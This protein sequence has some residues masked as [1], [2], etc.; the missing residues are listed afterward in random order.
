MIKK[1]LHKLTNYF[2]YNIRKYPSYNYDK[3][4]VFDLVINNYISKNKDQL[5]YFIQVGAHNGLKNDPINKYIKQNGWNGILIEP[6][7]NIF[8]ELKENYK[9]FS[10]NLIFENIAISS[11]ENEIELFS[12]K[13]GNKSTAA[14]VRKDVAK[15][16]LKKGDKLLQSIKVKSM[17]LKDLINKHSVKKIDLLQIDTEGYDFEVIKTLDL[18][19]FKP[20][21]IQF[22]F[23]HL[24]PKECNDVVKYLSLNNYMIHWGGREG[25]AIAIL[26]YVK[27]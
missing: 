21:I 14:S 8:N 26:K 4:N 3:V 6:Q 13:S 17:T 1:Y 15:R 19:N 7:K 10:K 16:Q 12:S 18:E 5:F 11:K 23:G 20:K 9:E 2:N 27:T 22:E 24:T 25:N